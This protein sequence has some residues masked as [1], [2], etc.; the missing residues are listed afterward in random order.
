MV[1]WN[2]ETPQRCNNIIEYA[3]RYQEQ[4]WNMLDEFLT[5]THHHVITLD[6]LLRYSDGL[7]RDSRKLQEMIGGR[8]GISD[9]ARDREQRLM[10]G[11]AGKVWTEARKELIGWCK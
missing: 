8:V 11:T 10:E 2:S 5:K 9:I 3:Y 1:R 7:G 6:E 4:E